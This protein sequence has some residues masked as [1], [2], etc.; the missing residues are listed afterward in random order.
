MALKEVPI[1][2]NSAY[3]VGSECIRQCKE[4]SVKDKLCSVLWKVPILCLY[5]H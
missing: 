4:L 3:G 1:V 2:G 5:I